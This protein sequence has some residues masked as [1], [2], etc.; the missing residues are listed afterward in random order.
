MPLLSSF[1]AWSLC[2]RVA[3]VVKPWGAVAVR[4]QGDRWE[5]DGGKAIKPPPAEGQ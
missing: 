1:S 2:S 5:A 3:L 4:G